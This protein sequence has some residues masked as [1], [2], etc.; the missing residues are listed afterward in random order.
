[1]SNALS[2]P[3]KSNM[4]IQGALV[5]RLLAVQVFGIVSGSLRKSIVFRELE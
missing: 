3:K 2:L 4:G 5:C 1:M